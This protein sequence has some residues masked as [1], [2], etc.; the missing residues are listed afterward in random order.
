MIIEGQPEWLAETSFDG[1]LAKLPLT[2]KLQ[3]PFR[4]DMSGELL[5]LNTNFHWRGKAEVHNFDLSAFGAGDALGIVTGTL[6]IGGEMNA[7]HARGPLQIPGLGAGLFDLAF[8]GNYTDGVVNATHYEV[9]HRATGSHVDGAGTIEVGGQRSE[10]GA[11]RPLARGALAAGRA[12]HRGDSA[13]LQQSA[14]Q[15]PPRRC[16]ALRAHGQRRPVRAAAR[17]DD[18]RACAA[19]LHKDHLEIEQLD[20]GAFG[21]RALLAGEAR[22]NPEERWALEGDVKGFNPAELRPGFNG[23]LDF[24]LKAAGEPFDSN[25]LDVSFSDLSGKLR[26]NTASGSGR[27]LKDGEDWTFEKLRLRAGTTRFQLDGNVGP[28]RELNLDFS[29]DADNLGLLAEGSRGTLH[30]RG[31]IAGTSGTP[32]IRLDAQGAGIE[33]RGVQIDKL[34]ANVDVD[35]RGQRA[36][37]ADIAISRLTFDERELTQFNAVLDGTTSEHTFK[38]DA[39][40]ARTNLHLAGKGSFKDRRVE[41]HDRGPV[42]RR[43]RQHQARARRAGGDSWRAP[44]PS[45]STRCACTARWRAC[46]AKAPGTRPAGTRAPRRAT[47]PSARSP[48]G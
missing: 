26:G 36:S 27:V 34:S 29:I 25:H 15:L 5:E 40:A 13:A 30:A 12:L 32:V 19:R 35:W 43:R 2:G 4:A 22:W 6:D 33:H 48:P 9:T 20:L 31:R 8:E 28:T 46:A 7:F 1:D 24:R 3:T 14:G 21:G 42:H 17:T 45:G 11:G 37:H 38:V 16:L 41:R 44:R 23:A 10:A 18:L 39:L 47:C